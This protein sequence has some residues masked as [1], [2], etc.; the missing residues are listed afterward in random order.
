MKNANQKLII[1]LA[2]LCG[3]IQSPKIT[4]FVENE[5]EHGQTHKTIPHD[6]LWVQET[7]HCIKDAEPVIK[8]LGAWLSDLIESK[9]LFCVL[10]KNL[11]GICK[12][13]K[14][15]MTIPTKKLYETY[16]KNIVIQEIYV[17][18]ELLNECLEKHLHEPLAKSFQ[19]AAKV[20]QIKRLMILKGCFESIGTNIEKDFTTLKHRLAD[21]LSICHQK[22]LKSE[23][24]N[25]LLIL[26]GI[27]TKYNNKQKIEALI[28]K[29]V[30]TEFT[31]NTHYQKLT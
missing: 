2:L 24:E 29:R 28:K 23:I 6:A 8:D 26:E 19:D 20:G 10:V 17:F 5:P 1:I 14:E 4:C 16:K 11:D 9:T 27:V 12:K 18:I 22:E 21:L 7:I 3:L 15:K 13:Y 25:V 30:T 31:E